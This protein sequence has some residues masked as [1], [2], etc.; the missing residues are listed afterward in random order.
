[1]RIAQPAPWASPGGQPAPPP[2]PPPPKRRK[3]AK[4]RPV[5][6]RVNRALYLSALADAIESHEEFAAIH[7]GEEPG[8]KHCEAGLNCDEY[9]KSARLLQRYRQAYT[10]TLAGQPT[11]RGAPR[12]LTGGQAREAAAAIRS[13]EPQADVAARLGVDRAT[14]RRAIG[15]LAGQ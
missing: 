15:R 13:G 9:K 4:R 12:K 7:R 6:V 3:A 8:I 10:T 5:Q 14:V 1:M 2:P 11:K